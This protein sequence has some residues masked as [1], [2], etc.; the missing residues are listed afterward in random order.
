MNHG[1]LQPDPEA[2]LAHSGW[3]RA[4]ARSLV[5]DPSAAEDVEQEAWRRALE[6]PPKHGGNL[7]AWLA[8]VVRSV[9]AQRGRTEGRAAARHERLNQ[10]ANPSTGVGPRQA[11]PQTPGEIAERMETFQAP[12]RFTCALWRSCR[13][14]KSPRAKRC[15]CRRRR[16]AF[17]AGSSCCAATCKA[18]SAA[19]GK[20]VVWSSHRLPVRRRFP[21]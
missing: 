16:R 13:L 8:S 1:P 14:P 2:L 5:A 15:R 21:L 7:R 6:S 18:A 4:L 11:P 17:G 10:A 19:L 12:R 9:A 3:V 20:H